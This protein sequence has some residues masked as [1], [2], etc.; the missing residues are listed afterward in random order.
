MFE[1]QQLKM[2]SFFVDDDVNIVILH[3]KYI[4]FHVNYLVCFQL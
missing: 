1:L 4:Y 2:D 3:M